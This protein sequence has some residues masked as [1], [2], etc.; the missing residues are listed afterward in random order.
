MLAKERQDKIRAILQRDGAVTTSALMEE[1]QVSIETVRRDFLQME[2]KGLLTRVHGGAVLSGE[3]GTFHNLE[4][5]NKAYS[6]QKK[7]LARIAAGFVSDGDYIGVDSGST[8]VA[9]AEALKEQCSRLTIVTHSVDVFEVLRNY[10]DFN[11]I[12]CGGFY[13]REENA[14]YGSMALEMLEGLHL[15]KAFIFPSAISMECGIGDFQPELFQVQKKM[16]EIADSVFVL[17]DSSKF[18]KKALLKLADMR[19][20]YTYITDSLL[21]KEL[22]RIYEE[23]GITVCNA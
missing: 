22:K 15:Q 16:K 7:E 21:P 1:F 14:M 6:E 18:E 19:P 2:Q 9:F 17:A 8:A 20:E 3:M 5:R 11:V 12:L 10:K 13:L 23:N 4:Y